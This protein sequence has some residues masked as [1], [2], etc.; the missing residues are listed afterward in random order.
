M[1]HEEHEGKAEEHEG[2]QP[3]VQSLLVRTKNEDKEYDSHYGLH[4]RHQHL[5]GRL[6]RPALGGQDYSL[7]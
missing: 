4:D 7:F 5:K 6:R 2:N 3:D 1:E